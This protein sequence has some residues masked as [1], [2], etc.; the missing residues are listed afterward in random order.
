MTALADPPKRREPR[1]KNWNKN[2][3]YAHMLYTEALKYL[4]GYA[5]ALTQSDGHCRH[6]D[7]TMIQT[8]DH[9]YGGPEYMCIMDRRDMQLLV[10][11][12]YIILHHPNQA[13]DCFH[14]RENVGWMYGVGGSL[15]ENSPVAKWMRT[16]GRVNL[17]EFYE[18][19]GQV[20]NADVRKYGKLYAQHFSD[21]VTG[22]DVMAPG[23]FP[24]DITA[25]GLPNL[26]ACAGWVPMY[27]WDSERNKKNF[28]KTRGAYAYAEVLG[29]W[30]LIRIDAINGEEVGAEIGMVNQGIDTFYPFHNHAIPE[31]YYT[32]REPACAEEFN[33]FAI[34][35]NNPLLMTIEENEVYR[36][37]EFDGSDPANDAFW[38]PTSTKKDDL[39]YFHSNTIHAFHIKG[40]DCHAKPA[41]KAIVTVWARSMAHDRRN[42]YGTTLLCESAAVPDTPAIKDEKWRCDLTHTKWRKRRS[43]GDTTPVELDG[44]NAPMV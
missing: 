33:N 24:F 13:E 39:I 16:L 3:K 4:E 30:G 19:E 1:Y 23:A 17:S 22:S 5:M 7:H 8:N 15:E 6:S 32:I 29:H 20:P 35:E 37:V 18:D 40:E 34:R 21:M 25:N 2:G 10:K 43:A 38:V 41:E 12:I 44:F 9:N 42:D 26:W 31:I 14:G 36:Q 27:A 11:H 28:I